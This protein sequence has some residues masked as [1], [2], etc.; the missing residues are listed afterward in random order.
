MSRRHSRLPPHA[1]QGAQLTGQ[2]LI[3]CVLLFRLKAIMD[4][5]TTFVRPV[6]LGLRFS[7][8][9]AAL[10]LTFQALSAAQKTKVP[11][12]AEAIYA[13]GM[14]ALRQ[15][16]LSAAEAAFEKV[17]RLAPSS[18]APARLAKAHFRTLI[19]TSCVAGIRKG[20]GRFSEAGL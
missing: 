10:F 12:Q 7:V 2:T 14:Q 8:F 6:N 20:F 11:G 17:L 18:A 4:F 9:A 16:D 3:P 1:G 5:V 19:P 15:G 13:Q